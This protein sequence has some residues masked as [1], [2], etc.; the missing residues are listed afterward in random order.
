LSALAATVLPFP[1]ENERSR[2]RCEVI[3]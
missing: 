1:Q 3:V 2:K